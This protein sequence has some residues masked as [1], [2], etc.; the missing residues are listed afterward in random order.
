[1]QFKETDLVYK[2]VHCDQFCSHI[3][4]SQHSI[5]SLYSISQMSITNCINKAKCCSLSL[6]DDDLRFTMLSVKLNLQHDG[7]DAPRQAGGL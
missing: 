2:Q 6:T 7:C 5:F 4:D 3:V 1:M